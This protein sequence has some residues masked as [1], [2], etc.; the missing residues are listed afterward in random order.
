VLFGEPVSIS[1]WNSEAFLRRVHPED[2]ARVA[3]EFERALLEGSRYEV[4]FRVAQPDGSMRWL[5][6]RATPRMAGSQCIGL[7]GVVLDITQRK[8]QEQ[9]LAE[10]EHR[11]E[12]MADSAPVLLW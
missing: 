12:L 3:Q 1:A 4:E 2:R 9:A 5:V 10:S 11:F 6:S 8:R 7:G